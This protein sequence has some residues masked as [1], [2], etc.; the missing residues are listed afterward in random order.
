VGDPRLGDLPF[1]LED[2]F[3]GCLQGALRIRIRTEH[4]NTVCKF[5]LG[6]LVSQVPQP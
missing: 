2:T 4:R 5:L 3:L 1:L 6:G